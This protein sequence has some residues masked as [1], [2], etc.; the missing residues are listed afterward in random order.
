[1]VR[2]KIWDSYDVNNI[3]SNKYIYHYTSLNTGLEAILKNGTIRLSPFSKV[4]DPK[5]SKERL[6]SV[7]LYNNDKLTK[8]DFEAIRLEANRML[9]NNCKKPSRDV[10]CV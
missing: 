1:M 10:F 5:E 6:L 2:V 8:D 4:N 9:V 7:S 3:D